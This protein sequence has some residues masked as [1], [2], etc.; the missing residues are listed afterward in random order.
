L[1]TSRLPDALVADANA[2]IS[3]VIGGRATLVLSNPATPVVFST[4]AARQEVLAWLPSLAAKRKLDLG[5]LLAILQV[6]PIEWIEESQYKDSEE[7]AL[8]RIGARDPEDWPTVAL[9]LSLRSSRTVRI[10]TADKDFSI[11]GVDVVTTG[12][13]LDELR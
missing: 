9:A 10:W 1:P 6:L 13:L 2:I 8:R 12:A 5:R 11:A 3:A 4:A 7:E